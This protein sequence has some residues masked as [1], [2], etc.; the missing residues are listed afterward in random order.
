MC[1]Q[2]SVLVFVPNGF[3]WLATLVYLPYIL[4]F[5]PG[6]PLPATVANTTKTVLSILLSLCAVTAILTQTGVAKDTPPYPTAHYVARFCEG[7]TYLLAAVLS[8]LE[9]K[10]GVINSGLLFVYWL[11]LALVDL[12]PLYTYILMDLE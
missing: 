4:G 6:P 12:I 1:F 3:L 5:P 9:R 10:R 2:S 11:L 7:F 8:Q